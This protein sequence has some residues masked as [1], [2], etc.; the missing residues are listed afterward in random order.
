MLKNLASR[1]RAVKGEG[2]MGESRGKKVTAL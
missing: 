1:T 2:A